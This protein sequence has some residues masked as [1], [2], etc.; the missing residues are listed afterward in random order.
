MNSFRSFFLAAAVTSL[1]GF[2]MPGHTAVISSANNNPYAFSWS[3]NTG[4]SILSGSGS[5]TL[6]GFNSSALTV[7]ASLT[8]TSAIGGNGG[9]RLVGFGFGIDPNATAVSFSD[10][11]DG[12]MVSAGFASGALPANI[13]GVEICAWGG[14][15]CSGGG[16]GGIYAG[17]SDTFSVVL[18]GTWGSSV[19]V[20][21]IGFRYQ[22]GYGSFEFGLTPP[23]GGN[24][25]VGT[26]PTGSP[27]T[28]TVP[29]PG[30]LA[31]LGLGLAGL[32][33]TRRRKQ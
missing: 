24:P 26:P 20:E 10:A 22:T 4:S 23:P 12:G 27:P 28:G 16:N 5:M 15:N 14:N 17:T 30:T 25:P 8:N 21:P 19:N 6:S 2:A 31:L 1:A 33:A 3:Y 11:N 32:A 18:A 29:E 7:T 9:E 13:Q